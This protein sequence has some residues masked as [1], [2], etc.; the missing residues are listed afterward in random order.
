ML[1]LPDEKIKGPRGSEEG[2]ASAPTVLGADHD[3]YGLAKWFL[4]KQVC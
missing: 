3:Y 4:H 1:M 2:W